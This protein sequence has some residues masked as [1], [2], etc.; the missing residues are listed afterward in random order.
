MFNARQSG[1]ASGCDKCQS[2]NGKMLSLAPP[3]CRNEREKA[4]ESG[5]R[6][7]VR[8]FLP[9]VAVHDHGVA[10]M[11]GDVFLLSGLSFED[12]FDVDLQGL[13]AAVAG[14]AEYNHAGL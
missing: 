12:A 2:A 13:G 3:S 5:E 14:G 4:R 8:Q 7:D 1:I 11:Q 6:Q 9:G 10:G